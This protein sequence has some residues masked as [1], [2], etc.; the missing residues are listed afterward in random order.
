MWS[1]LESLYPYVSFK[2]LLHSYLTLPNSVLLTE[3][4]YAFIFPIRATRPARL[5]LIHLVVFCCAVGYVAVCFGK[6]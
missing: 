4:F 1:N 3:I 5:L 2:H 6:R